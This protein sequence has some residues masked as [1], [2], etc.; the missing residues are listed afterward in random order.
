MSKITKR[1]SVRNSPTAEG[2][3]LMIKMMIDE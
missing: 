1:E 3:V 2:V